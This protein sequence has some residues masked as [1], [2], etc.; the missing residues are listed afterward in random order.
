MSSKI[1]RGAQL[2]AETKK[3]GHKF[4]SKDTA[5]ANA[6]QKS[7]GIL[8][9]QKENV[10][11]KN[12]APKVHKGYGQQAELKEQN[13]HLMTVNEELQK[14][15]TETQNRVAELELQFSDLEKKNAGVEKNLKDC[16]VLLVGAK[17]DPVLGER[18]GE[19]AQQNEDQRKEAMSISTDLLNELRTFS[20]IASQQRAQLRE[21]Q[22]T[23]SDL[24][25]ARE[26]MIQERENFSLEAA[27]MEEALKEAEALL[28]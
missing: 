2:P 22:T 28:L 16:H 26:H 17:I 14:N 20:D 23:M 1:P 9:S 15:L 13:Q 24:T 19:A 11:R 7:D 25:K 10:P 18:V 12:V 27:E 6:A 3:T 21:I 8:K 4:E 5:T